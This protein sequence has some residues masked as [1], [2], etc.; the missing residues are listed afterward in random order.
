MD[1]IHQTK[2]N[3]NG[4]HYV[5]ADILYRCNYNLGRLRVDKSNRKIAT[6]D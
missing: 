6:T 4:K 5:K 2:H 1:M 3:S